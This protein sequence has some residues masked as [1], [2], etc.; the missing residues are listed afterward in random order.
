MK[1]VWVTWPAALIMLA[2]SAAA[3]NDKQPE[4][5]SAPSA[6]HGQKQPPKAAPGKPQSPRSSDIQELK[7]IG[8]EA[9]PPSAAVTETLPSKHVPQEPTTASPPSRE[10]KPTPPRD[11]DSTENDDSLTTIRK[12]VNEVNVVFVVID[13]HGHYVRD[14]RK[15]NFRVLDDNKPAKE[16]RSFRN[17]TDLPLQVGLL[18]DASNSV[19]DRFKFEQEAAIEFLNQIIR[20]SYDKAFVIGFDT[21]PEITQD[22]TDSTELLS[23]GVRAL[24]AGGG[25][26][27]YDALYFACRDKLKNAPRKGPVRRAIILLSDGEDNQSRVTREEAIE[28]AQRA[29]VIVYTISTNVS[30][31]KRQGD[32]ILERIADATGGRPFFPFQLRDV[33]NDFA[34]IQNELRSQYALA[35]IP[36]DFRTDG[37]FRSI[38]ITADQKG[39]HVRSRRGYY[40]PHNR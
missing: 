1:L 25:T 30:G 40:A 32:K 18:V 26:A 23:R 14:L 6:V 36:E 29:D 7:P 34:E 17:E 10:A 5:P 11:A 27:M 2:F 12:T 9:P 20:P 39:F 4:L 8:Q 28:M 31:V 22:F 35:Y 24:R 38:Q 3:Q 16:I 13:K 21:T 19:R 37:R 15:D 33:S